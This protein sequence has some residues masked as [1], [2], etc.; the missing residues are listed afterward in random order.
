MHSDVV[1]EGVLRKLKFVM[2]KRIVLMD[3]M[4]QTAEENLEV[5]SKYS[6]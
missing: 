1:M 3:Q 2:G 6:R 4:K 5:V